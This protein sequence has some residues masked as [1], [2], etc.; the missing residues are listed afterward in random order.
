MVDSEPS[1]LFRPVFKLGKGLGG[2]NESAALCGA[3]L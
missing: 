2:C 3:E 1:G